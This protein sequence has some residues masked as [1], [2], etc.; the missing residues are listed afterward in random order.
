MEVLVQVPAKSLPPQPSWSEY[1]IYLPRII[2]ASDSCQARMPTFCVSTALLELAASNDK[3]DSCSFTFSDAL[4][5]CLGE[6][7]SLW[8]PGHSDPQRLK[9]QEQEV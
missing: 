1:K 5:M 9:L 4:T 2:R 6:L 7:T 8:E 3:G